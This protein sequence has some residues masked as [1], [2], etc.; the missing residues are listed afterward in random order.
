MKGGVDFYNKKNKCFLSLQAFWHQGLIK[1]AE[2]TV[3]YRYGY[4]SYP[5]YQRD[6][7]VVLKSRGTVYGVTAGVPIRIL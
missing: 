3:N 2:Y 7:T 4:F 6:E 1:M 5:E